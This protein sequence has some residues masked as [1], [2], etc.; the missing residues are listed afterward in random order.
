MDVVEGEKE[1]V[2]YIPVALIA[3]IVAQELMV[4][5]ETRDYV[6]KLEWDVY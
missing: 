5:I 2:E 3:E 6:K 4:E 1:Q